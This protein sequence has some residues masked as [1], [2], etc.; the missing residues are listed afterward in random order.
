[1]HTNDRERW[2][3]RRGMSRRQW[4]AASLVLGGSMGLHRSDPQSR[5][6]AQ[7]SLMDLPVIDTHQHLWDLD[8]FR[9]P[10]LQTE[11]VPAL[12]R[13]FVMS[14]YLQATRGLNV[15]KTVYMEVDVAPEQQLAEAEYV[16]D[17]CARDDNPLAGAV[18]S[19]RPA[20]PD[21]A[22]YIRPLARHSYLKGVRQ[23]L[24]VPSTPPGYCL[25]PKFVHGIQLLGD[26]GLRFDLCMRPGELYDA[27]K[28][29]EQCP[30][31]QFIVDHCG[32]MSVS[33]RDAELR[34]K[35]Q[36][37]MQAL[38]ALPNTVCKISGIVVTA[39]PK[40]TPADLAPNIQFTLDTFGA[41]RVLFAGDW[42]VCTL[43]ATFAQWLSALKEIVQDRPLAFQRKLFHDNAVRVYGLA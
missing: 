13:S 17:L 9:L 1:M 39:P 29:V 3:A 6:A 15:V 42:P 14:D 11:D 5:V 27:V 23:V 18:I 36:G 38:A 30:R 12:R 26:L 31:T 43:R 37:A 33:S 8:R 20:A 34:K 41:D 40:W 2:F 24:H 21:F 22:A 16:F 32:N 28:L 19:G 25:Q 7:E 35:W 10:W 4:L